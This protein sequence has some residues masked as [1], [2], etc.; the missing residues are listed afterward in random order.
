MKTT[1][2]K[3]LATT[4]LLSM[5]LLLLFVSVVHGGASGVNV[6][7]ESYDAG[8]VIVTSFEVD[9]MNT[10]ISGDFAP[11]ALPTSDVIQE[12]S[13]WTV[14]SEDGEYLSGIT[15][16]G[17]FLELADFGA[18][19]GAEQRQYVSLE[20]AIHAAFP[21]AG[22]S[23]A[24]VAN[25]DYHVFARTSDI[26]N[27]ILEARYSIVFGSD[28]AW[29]VDGQMSILHENGN[30]EILP[31]F[32]DLF[33]HWN[34]AQIESF[35]VTQ[36]D[37]NTETHYAN[38]SLARFTQFFRASGT[39]HRQQADVNAP[40]FTQFVNNTGRLINVDVILQQMNWPVGGVNLGITN[41]QTGESVGWRG[42]L[43]PGQGITLNNTP[44]NAVRGVRA[45][46]IDNSGF[47]VIDGF[48]R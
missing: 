2:S 10:Q 39:I 17:D 40:V 29:T 6:D 21:F 1:F 37:V 8:G 20:T 44:A 38:D 42:G 3:K 15:A 35:A 43:V 24:D 48:W 23:I 41:M 16:T 4:S 25:L 5:A 18:I 22:Y 9:G 12:P 27:L 31:E 46:T 30:V 47:V 34:L 33:P 7:A 13:G 11:I 28:V 36:F 19:F 45:S 32:N 14:R 26:S